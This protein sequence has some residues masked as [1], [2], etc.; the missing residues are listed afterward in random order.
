MRFSEFCMFRL[1]NMHA[2]CKHTN[3]LWNVCTQFLYREDVVGNFSHSYAFKYK[4]NCTDPKINLSSMYS[5]LM[6][7]LLIL[8]FWLGLTAPAQGIKRALPSVFLL[9]QTF[10]VADTRDWQ[11]KKTYHSFWTVIAKSKE[12]FLAQNTKVVDNPD[13]EST[14]D[15]NSKNE[16]GIVPLL[17]D[18]ND[19]T[20]QPSSTRPWKAKDDNVLYLSPKQNWGRPSTSKVY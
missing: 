18:R 15:E 4:G 16:S 9:Q 11:S 2:K 6:F 13:F 8:L 7:F 10:S 12:M 19:G 5:K 17:K 1:M 3:V 20:Q 14:D